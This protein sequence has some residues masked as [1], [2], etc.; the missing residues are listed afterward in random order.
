MERLRT[1]L[2][3][4]VRKLASIS[5]GK[6]IAI[7]LVLLVAGGVVYVIEPRIEISAGQPP[8]PARPILTPFAV[9]NA[10]FFAFRD[11]HLQCVAQAVEFERTLKGPP[12]FFDKGVV[13]VNTTSTASLRPGQNL[14]VACSKGFSAETD[15]LLHADLDLNVCLKPYPLID[16]ISLEHFR[17]VGERGRD[18]GMHW[19]RREPRRSSI[20]WMVADKQP[21]ECQWAE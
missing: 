18:G 17:Y 11:V 1:S 10:G 13:N 12:F 21:E 14:P 15:K 16:Y 8:D 2:N 9:S 4:D 5:R 19:E 7:L 3:T 20:R 6:L